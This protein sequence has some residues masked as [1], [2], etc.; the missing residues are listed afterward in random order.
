MS[1]LM[2]SLRLGIFRTICACSFLRRKVTDTQ[3]W[4]QTPKAAAAIKRRNLLP[5]VA[6]V[7]WTGVAP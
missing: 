1:A 2:R 6:I 3:A 5:Q 4:F 7:E